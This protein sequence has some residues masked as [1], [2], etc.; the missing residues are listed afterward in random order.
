ML[1]FKQKL[2]SCSYN[3][4]TYAK[5]LKKGKYMFKLNTNPEKEFHYEGRLMI[6]ILTEINLTTVNYKF[7]IE[8]LSLHWNSQEILHKVVMRLKYFHF[9]VFAEDFTYPMRNLY[10][11]KRIYG[12]ENRFKHFS[13]DQKSNSMHLK[14]SLGI[15]PF[16]ACSGKRYW[17]QY[18]RWQ[19]TINR[20]KDTDSVGK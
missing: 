14:I 5:H 1:S 15:L 6:Q 20:E 11:I 2:I 9:L 13:R 17:Y 4:F 18:F 19:Y 7:K 8:I 10:K 3:K 12:T 16:L